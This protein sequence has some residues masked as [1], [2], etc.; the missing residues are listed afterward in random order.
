MGKNRGEGNV[1]RAFPRGKI[2]SEDLPCIGL[3]PAHQQLGL[4]RSKPVRR[5][6]HDDHHENSPSAQLPAVRAEAAGSFWRRNG[7]TAGTLNVVGVSP[8]HYF[9]IYIHLLRFY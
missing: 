5:A 7:G 2:G 6:N 9:V 8:W 4:D 3:A 1:G